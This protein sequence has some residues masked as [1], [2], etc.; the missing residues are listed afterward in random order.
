VASSVLDVLL[1]VLE[2]LKHLAVAFRA[3]LLSPLDA[4]FED[5]AMSSTQSFT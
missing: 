1:H 4:A 3:D 5:F 2:A